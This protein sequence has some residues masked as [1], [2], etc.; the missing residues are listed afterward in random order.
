M[1]QEE[2]S[3]LYFV[4]KKNILSNDKI[5]YRIFNILLNYKIFYLLIKCFLLNHLIKLKSYLYVHEY[6]C[7]TTDNCINNFSIGTN[8]DK[9]ISDLTMRQRNYK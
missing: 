3:L 2:C 6:R 9:L 5:F 1:I 8:A 7:Y 4:L